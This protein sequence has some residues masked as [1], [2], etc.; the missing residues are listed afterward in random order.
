MNI[1]KILSSALIVMLVFTM[2]A[3]FIPVRVDAAYS[4][5]SV[6]TQSLTVDQIKSIVKD[7]YKDYGQ[8]FN[9]AEER[10]VYEFAQGY[11][12]Y[13]YSAG[14]EYTIYV[15]RYNGYVYY[16]NNLTGQIL[17]SNPY[18]V[19]GFASDATKRSLLNQI[20]IKFSLDSGDLP[21]SNGVLSGSIDA[22][23]R[24]QISTTLIAGGIRVNYTIGDTTTRYYTPIQ[25]TAESFNEYILTPMLDYYRD[26]LL[27]FVSDSSASTLDNYDYYEQEKWGSYKTY[28]D[29]GHVIMRTVAEYLEITQ[30]DY[31]K[32]YTSADDEIRKELDSLN[33]EI[34]RIATSYNLVEPRTYNNSIVPETEVEKLN[35]EY[36][37]QNPGSEV[38]IYYCSKAPAKDGTINNSYA[39]HLK[40]LQA[41]IVKYAGYTT[42]LLALHESE[43]LYVYPIAEN[44]VFR[45]SI[46]YT[47]NT[48]GT[49][50]I[51]LPVNSISFDEEVYNLES[52]T[53][54]QFFG[55]GDLT[56]DGYVFI[57]DG[58]GSV[59]E[60]EDFYKS[61][62][63]QNVNLKLSVYGDDFAYANPSGKHKEQISMPV[64]GL[65]G[66]VSTG[67]GASVQAENS[68]F[69]AILEEG[70]S[71]A[72]LY[73][74]FGG[75]THHYS[76]VYASYSPYPSDQYYLGGT[77]GVGASYTIVS[78]SKY[79]G[80]YVTRIVMLGDERDPETKNVASYVGMAGYY[81]D[82]LKSRGELEAIESFN[83]DIPLYIEALGSMTVME[84]ILTFPVSVSKALTK[85]DDIVT[86][87]KELADVTTK[88]RAKAEEYRQKS[89]AETENKTL[90]EKYLA[91]AEEYDRLVAEMES[92]KNINFKLTGF[93]N[94][95]MYFT[96]P[97]SVTWEDACGGKNGFNSLIAQADSL[98][99]GVYPEFD[100][101]YMSNSAW[102]DGISETTDLS[103]MVDNRYASKQVYNSVLGVYQS[104][105]SMVISTDALDRLYTQ[106]NSNY[107]VYGNKK[108]SVSTLGSDLN[109]NFD[110]EN[111][112][113]RN[114]SS[115]NI[116]A[117]LDRI[118]N[119]DG[120]E[121]MTSV[122]NSYAIGYSDHILDIAT[123]SSHFTYS[124]Y[125]VPFIGMVL[126]SYVSYAGTPINYSGSP[127]YEILRAIENGASLYY[128]LCY[129]NTEFMKEDQVLN[130]YYGIDYENWYDK[131]VQQYNVLNDAIGAYQSYE[132]VDHKIVIGERVI[133]EKEALA[134]KETLKD[135]F[136]ALVEAKIIDEINAAFD[137]MSKDIANIGRGVSL[138]VNVTA[139]V[140]QAVGALNISADELNAVTDNGANDTFVEKLIALVAKYNAEYTDNGDNSTVKISAI[141]YSTVY[142]FVTDSLCD[143]D[144]YDYTDYTADTKRVAVVTYKNAETGDVVRFILNYNV[145][146]VTVK[147]DADTTIELP[148][149]G[150]AKIDG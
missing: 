120:Y 141:E 54:L 133:D 89:A 88:F 51:R 64:Y 145:Y 128:I 11:L 26:M 124:S 148:K 87:Y 36:Y 150:F 98:G 92:I 97:T 73:V 57:P 93:A 122:G 28:N 46:E 6:G 125:T 100:F 84:K 16:K 23:E 7:A 139:L 37:K 81:R 38:A 119:A 106:F 132:I 72:T 75:S 9:S 12:D 140:E 45:C 143:D 56:K 129:D 43:C 131:L 52:L 47:F 115:N 83:E 39:A 58:S 80:S 59:I 24:G 2:F 135:E 76:N 48:D 91:R 116:A 25:I 112:I 138:N 69:F 104:F 147:L 14:G 146:S 29:Y 22:A 130:D 117:L 108:L 67:T 74:T 144:D 70:A 13:V 65:T 30:N 86:M 42:E 20:S 15:N 35:L 31:R 8:T 99:F 101:A 134:N 61:Y 21:P 105:Y 90:H 62:N 103:R 68:G 136:I 126:H 5:G 63:K 79:T 49:L 33:A 3:G 137:E 82:Y 94:G 142:D 27:E 118:A 114:E 85:F 113:N 55:A 149:F 44:P 19:S 40:K 109:S 77:S 41:S 127:D 121:V 10:L 110:S 60:Y 123:D 95:G 96:Y 111:P 1:K 34:K 18:S 66:V 4:A 32:V 78:D 17:T 107:S 50:S 102:F 71:L 53:P